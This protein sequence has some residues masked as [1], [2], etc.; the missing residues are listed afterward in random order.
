[1]DEANI[2]NNRRDYHSLAPLLPQLLDENPNSAEVAFIAANCYDHLD[3]FD[4][5]ESLY[6][7]SIELNGSF[8]DPVYNLGIVYFREGLLKH[9]EESNKNIERAGQWLEKASEI[10][11]NDIKCLQLLQLVYTKTGN[12]DQ[13]EKINSKLKLLTNQ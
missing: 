3:N 6:L 13:V 4:K 7:R 2:Y 5:A 1:L 11:P 12:Q 9:G 10:S 8:Y